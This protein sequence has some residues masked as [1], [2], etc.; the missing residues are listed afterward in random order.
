[1]TGSRSWNRIN[2][3]FEL[4]VLKSKCRADFAA[5]KFASLT[6]S[7]AAPQAE[8]PNL[9]ILEEH[10]VFKLDFDEEKLNTPPNLESLG[11]VSVEAVSST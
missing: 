9:K 5:H 4:Q 2:A 7:S 11:E 1:L 8:N 3:D 10:G 6:Q